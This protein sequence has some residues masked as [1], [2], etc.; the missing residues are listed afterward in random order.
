MKNFILSRG[1]ASYGAS[2]AV[3]CL[4]TNVG[5]TRMY[6]CGCAPGPRCRRANVTHGD[7]HAGRV[8]EDGQPEA[9]H[10][11]LERRILRFTSG[12]ARRKV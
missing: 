7:T 9:P 4:V 6:D 12:F 8:E 3:A 2:R 1:G 10:M 5:G 11:V